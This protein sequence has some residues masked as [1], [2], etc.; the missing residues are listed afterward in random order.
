MRNA[1][2]HSMMKPFV[3]VFLDPAGDGA[4]R[5][6]QAAMPRSCVLSGSF[7]SENETQLRICRSGGFFTVEEP[8]FL[9]FVAQCVTAD[10]QE[11]R[12]LGLIAAGL[13]EG[14]FHQGV[15][16]FFEGGAPI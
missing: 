5:F 1:I 13:T 4:P 2:L 9:H 3:V 16:D 12:S 15:F 14:E 10:V 6:F 11:S 7:R 8:K